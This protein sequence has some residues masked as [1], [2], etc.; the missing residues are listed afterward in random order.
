M[1]GVWCLAF[2]CLV[3]SVGHSV[4]GGLCSIMVVCRL[5]C[6]DWCLVFW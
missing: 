5:V 3:F 4:L 6:G 2:C 1:F